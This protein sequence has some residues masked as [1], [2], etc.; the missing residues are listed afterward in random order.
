MYKINLN[1]L[2][3]NSDQ[4]GYCRLARQEERS[5]ELVQSH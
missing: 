3:N 4:T 2:P 1:F 5:V